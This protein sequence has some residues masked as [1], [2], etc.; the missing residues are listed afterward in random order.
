MALK[1]HQYQAILRSY[2]ATRQFHRRELE[3]R[4]QHIYETLPKLKELDDQIVEMSIKQAKLSLTGDASALHGLAEK[5]KL[6][7]MQKKELLRAAGF[8]EDYLELQYTCPDCKD[9]G[10]IEKEKCHCFRQAITDLLYSDSGLKDALEKENFSTFS[11]RY[12]DDTAVDPALGITP[13][14]NITNVLTQVRQFLD[15]FDTSFQNLFLYGNTG[16]GKTFLSN[17]IA[18][19]LLDTGHHVIYLTAYELFALF[20]KY[21]FR[22][23]T[24]PDSDIA[25]QFAYL[26]DCD[27]LIIDDLGTELTNAFTNTRLYSCINERYLKK[28]STIISTNLSLS[29]FGEVYSERIFSRITG[30]YTLLKLIGGDIRVKRQLDNFNLL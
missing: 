15:T 27:L 11:F 6:C 28:K 13:R 25:E 2:D 23:D 14:Q 26:F 29:Q 7:S 19:E 4:R 21:T 8:P 3:E 10:Y 24:A 18:K 5:N 20:E 1:N 30:Y 16:V 17:C 22:N 12:F 9:T